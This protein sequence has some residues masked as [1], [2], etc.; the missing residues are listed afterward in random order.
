MKDRCAEYLSQSRTAMGSGRYIEAVRCCEEALK[1]RPAMAE[2]HY[3][4]GMCHMDSNEIDKAKKSFKK[5][6][7][8]QPENGEAYFGLGSCYFAKEKYVKALD[9]FTKAEKYGCSNKVRKRMYYHMGLINERLNNTQGARYYYD[10]ALSV[11]NEINADVKNILTRQM[12]IWI[13]L[14]NP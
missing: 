4:L 10:L 14:K 12:W 3:Q 6:V 1:I 9:A 7:K 11:D 8:L 5:A 13:R 2:A